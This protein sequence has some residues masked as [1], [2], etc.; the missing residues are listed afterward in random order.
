MK[1]RE[2]ERDKPKKDIK[3]VKEIRDKPKN[4]KKTKRETV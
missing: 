3:R 2:P 4:Q 1:K